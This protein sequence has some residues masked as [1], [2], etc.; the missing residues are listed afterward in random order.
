[1]RGR[2]VY[3]TQGCP[4]AL[5]R[6]S[7]NVYRVKIRIKVRLGFIGHLEGQLTAMTRHEAPRQPDA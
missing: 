5:L 1:M 7:R 3:P 4:D 6:L 2:Y